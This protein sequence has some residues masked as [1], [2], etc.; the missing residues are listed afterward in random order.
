M[1]TAVRLIRPHHRM[2]S[3]EPHPPEPVFFDHDGGIDDFV[4]LLFVCLNPS[5]KLLGVSVTPADCIGGPALEVTKKLLSIVG[6]KDVPT[7]EGT[8]EG[9]NPFP[10][11]WRIEVHKLALMPVVT[12]CE[13]PP[14]QTILSG[15]ELMAKCIL[16]SPAPVTVVMTGPLTNLAW[17]IQQHPKIVKNISR[18]VWMGGAVEVPGNVHQQHHDS[19]A[20]WNSFWDPL[21]A[22]QVIHAGIPEIRIF[23]L[24]CTNSVPVSD[25][26]IRGFG[27]Q[28]RDPV[29]N[30]VGG[31]WAQTADWTLKN[32][33]DPY[34]AWDALTAAWLL[35]RDLCSWK[36]MYIDVVRDG[37]SAGRTH[38][39][40]HVSGGCRVLVAHDV[41]CRRFHQLCWDAL[42]LPPRS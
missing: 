28:W 40:D 2:E 16:E 20:E 10:Y 19:S 12:G 29:S 23:S 18:L 4:A 35:D 6:L 8:L 15:Q 5:L 31:A 26:L 21:S 14:P 1:G 38:L 33:Q 32:G 24:D 11:E 9:V 37:T 41:D 34:Y 42:R 17:C 22:H 25:E 39:C 30:F 3:P 7:S 13:C 27:A 36:E